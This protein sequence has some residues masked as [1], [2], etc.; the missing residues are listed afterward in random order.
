[1]PWWRLSQAGWDDCSKP[2]RT[3][4]LDGT[5]FAPGARLGQVVLVNICASWCRPCLPEFPS[6][7][8]L[9]SSFAESNFAIVSAN[10]SEHGGRVKLFSMQVPVELPLLMDYHAAI[11]KDWI[12]YVYPSSY[13][14]DR[15][16]N[17]V[18]LTLEHWNGIQ[19]KT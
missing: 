7:H 10:F 13:L 12:I 3:G 8:R 15:K 5:A 2:L 6:L 4:D 9:D 18:T 17:N 19:P 16:G 14:V 1:M 11:S